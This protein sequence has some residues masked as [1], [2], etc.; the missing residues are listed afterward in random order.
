[1]HDRLLWDALLV[2]VT[3]HVLAILAYHVAKRQNLMVPMITG[4]KTLPRSVPAPQMPGPLRAL[5]CLSGAAAI[6]AA[7]ASYL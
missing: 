5:V 7:L 6:A 1:L 2:A 4:R 3:L